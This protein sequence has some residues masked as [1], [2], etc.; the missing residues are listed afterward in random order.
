MILCCLEAVT[1]YS[2]FSLEKKCSICK[3]EPIMKMRTIRFIH[4]NYM[5]GMKHLSYF[6]TCRECFDRDLLNKPLRLLKTYVPLLKMK[7]KRIVHTEISCTGLEK[8][9]W[10][11][12]NGDATYIKTLSWKDVDKYVERAKNASKV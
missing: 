10:G 9:I 3:T 1:N 2:A 5:D 11:V 12:D 7:S 6:L 4:Y 8:L